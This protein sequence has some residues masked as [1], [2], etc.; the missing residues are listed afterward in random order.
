MPD[1]LSS[2]MVNFAWNYLC[3]GRFLAISHKLFLVTKDVVSG[4]ELIGDCFNLGKDVLDMRS[5]ED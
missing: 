1:L 2:S 4:S 5:L 3:E